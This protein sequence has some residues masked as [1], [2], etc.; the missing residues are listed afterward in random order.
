M[1]KN[2]NDLEI[3][4]REDQAEMLHTIKNCKRF[5]NKSSMLEVCRHITAEKSLA[6]F[7]G[8]AIDSYSASAFVAVHDALK[9]DCRAILCKIADANPA[10]A[11]AIIWKLIK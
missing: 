2:L 5:K 4:E 1:R 11:M 8:T 6:R 7:K 3:T 9:P 10:K